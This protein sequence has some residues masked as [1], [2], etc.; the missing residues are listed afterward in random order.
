MYR[1]HVEA[2]LLAEVLAKTSGVI[3]DSLPQALNAAGILPSQ[4]A[5]VVGAAQ[6][7][8][9]G[10]FGAA[11]FMCC[12][13]ALVAVGLSVALMRAPKRREFGRSVQRQGGRTGWRG[14]YV[15]RRFCTGRDGARK[16]RLRR[17]IRPRARL[18]A[19][20]GTIAEILNWLELFATCWNV[21]TT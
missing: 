7:A 14:R 20:P 13:I 1:S 4:E 15:P 9:I 12:G 19:P 5:A 11:A 16:S 2:L 6:T 10:A 21:A 8:Y 18:L 3:L 17:E